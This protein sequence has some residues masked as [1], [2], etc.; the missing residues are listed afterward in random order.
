MDV[1]TVKR[2]LRINHTLLDAD[3]STAISEARLELVRAGVS[4]EQANGSDP[5]V[6]RAILT[7]CQMEFSNV[8]KIEKYEEAF[9]VQLDNLRKTPSYNG[10]S[11]NDGGE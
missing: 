2:T 5:L 1:A 9:R 11:A 4:E 10:A 6:E 7:Y 8:E 3:I